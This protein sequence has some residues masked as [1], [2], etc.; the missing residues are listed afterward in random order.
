[1]AE[2][3]DKAAPE[4][5]EDRKEQALEQ[6]NAFQVGKKCPKPANIVLEEGIEL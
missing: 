2:R 4:V 1:L 3:K 5:A 6:E